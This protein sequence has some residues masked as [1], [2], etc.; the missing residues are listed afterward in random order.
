MKKDKR[1]KDLLVK[2]EKVL[3][4]QEKFKEEKDQ[5]QLDRYYPWEDE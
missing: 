2:V 3:K 5:C 1:V 4:E